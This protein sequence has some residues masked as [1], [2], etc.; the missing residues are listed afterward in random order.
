MKKM[1][2]MS[3]MMALVGVTTF[4]LAACGDDEEKDMTVPEISDWGIVPNPINCQVYEP[5]DTIYFNY[6][7]A[8]DQ[9]LGSFAIEI[10]G[11]FDH[12]SHSTEADDHDH[13]H[14]GDD[15]HDHEGECHLPEA[16]RMLPDTAWVFNQSYTIPAGRQTY[17]AQP[18][19]A[20]PRTLKVST[21]EH[22]EGE[23]LNLHQGD[24][25]FM[26]RL[27]D[28]AGWQQLKAIAIRIGK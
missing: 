24:Y 21:K 3:L 7:M 27:T 16:A 12:H 15:D 26:V 11:N 13:D 5:G 1:K 19:I 28:R 2:Y 8:D 4:G 14:E 17:L 25:H 9:E 23:E 20:I 6:L 18:R 10:H 22:P